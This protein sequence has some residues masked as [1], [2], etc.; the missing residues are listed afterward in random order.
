MQILV[1]QHIACEPPGVFEDVLAERAH[2]LLRVELDEGEP[3]PEGT[4]DAIVAMG[5]PMSVNDESKHPWLAGEK[6]AIASHVR[7]GRPFWGSCLGAQLL[8]S[9]LGA[10]VYAGPA[11]EVGLLAVELT[12]AGVDDPVMGALP[13]AIDT[14]QWHGDTFDLP[15]GAVLLASSPAYPHQA[16]RVGRAAYAVQFHVE[17]TESMGEEWASV[18]AYAEYADR[19]LGPGGSDRLLAEFRLSSP[20]MQRHARDLF[21]RWCDLAESAQA[22]RA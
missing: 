9:A 19:V 17:V 7:A 6:A 16:F 11:P 10:R 20:L 13:A 14:L 4:W 21:E 1:L 18:P 22:G 2:E 5:G 12:A 8:A 15:E 3:L